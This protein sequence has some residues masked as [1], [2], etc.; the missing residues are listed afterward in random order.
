MKDIGQEIQQARLA[1]GVTLEEIAGHTHIQLA[2]LQKIENGQFDF[3]PRPYVVA[4]IKTFA[5]HVG[6]SGES[7]VKRWREEEQAE[8]LQL[9]EQQRQQSAGKKEDHKPAIPS[10][11]IK[12]PAPAA[13]PVSIPYLKEIAI[14]FGMVLV[15]V[16]LIY[17]MSRAGGE[18]AEGDARKVEQDNQPHNVQSGNSTRVQEI[19]FSQV[20]QEVAA[21]A[22][23]QK[24]E[25]QAPGELILQAQFERQT[26][27]RVIR[28]GADT[29][30]VVYR[31]GEAQTWRA[32]EKFNLRLSVAGVV[33][34][35]LDGKNLG[36]FGQPGQI[37][38][39]TITRGGVAEKFAITPRPRS[40][41]PR[42]SVVV[43]PLDD[44]GPRRRN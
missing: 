16:G 29:S 10:A 1:K 21:K 35:T 8:A 24:Q 20:S 40:T 34:L 22:Q 6:L 28:D 36:K 4:F 33:T 17:V 9:Q 25:Q 26:R 30:I 14:G 31:A 18:Q 27:M 13:K 2:H 42:D 12:P 37:E 23:A 5:Q 41:T 32:K 15:M 44:L 19:P 39:I 7:L 43:R 3:L 38:Y 11:P